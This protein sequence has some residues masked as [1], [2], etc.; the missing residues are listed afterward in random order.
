MRAPARQTV[1][2]TGII[3]GLVTGIITLF[4]ETI[5]ALS[6]NP[7]IATLQKILILPAMPGL[8]GSAIVG[9]LIFGALVTLLFYSVLGSLLCLFFKP[10]EPFNIS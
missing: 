6:A 5:T 1:F 10:K 4:A 2:W 7:F 9:S 3:V 8:F